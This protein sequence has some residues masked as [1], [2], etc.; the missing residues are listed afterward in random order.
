MYN[1]MSSIFFC[2]GGRRSCSLHLAK[3]A[4]SQFSTVN[5]PPHPLKPEKTLGR[6][7]S[8]PC[9]PPPPGRSSLA[10]LGSRGCAAWRGCAASF[11]GPACGWPLDDGHEHMAMRALPLL[12]SVNHRP[13]A[14][15]HMRLSLPLLYIPRPSGCLLHFLLNVLQKVGADHLAPVQSSCWE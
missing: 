15:K 7:R 11:C 3:R 10:S 13:A 8:P 1:E 12:T 2:K 9:T 14:E 5:A 6:R 4:S